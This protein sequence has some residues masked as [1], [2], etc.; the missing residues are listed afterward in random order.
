MKD[1]L[2]V[3]ILNCSVL[4]NV[5]FSVRGG[6][7]TA[8]IGKSSSG[9]SLLLKCIAGLCNY[10]GEVKIN[11]NVI[12]KSSKIDRNIGFFTGLS[13]LIPYTVLENIIES[14]INL[15]YDEKNARKKAYDILKKLGIENLAHKNI[16]VLSYSEKKMVAIAKSI[17]HEP[18]VILLDNVFDSLD[19]NYK[20][21]IVNYL[22]SLKQ[23]IV[24]FTCNNSE[25]LMFADDIIIIK[26]GKIIEHGKRNNLFE[27]ESTF[28]KNGIKLP[29]IID[30]SY[31]LIFYELTDHLIY[32]SKEMVDELW[33]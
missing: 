26:N 22:K 8:L 7:F 13:T 18:S 33:K 29:F 20:R 2:T 12:A 30:L 3:H 17:V 4:N 16:D 23:N 9:K 6:T 1:E 24:I 32:N 5:D 10:D 25:D 19:L 27:K 31:K 28:L 15:D 21:K 14:L 11:G